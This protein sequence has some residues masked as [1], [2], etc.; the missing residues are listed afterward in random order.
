MFHVER[1]SLIYQGFRRGGA[2]SS[3]TTMFF[4]VACASISAIAIIVKSFL[5]VWCKLF[6]IVPVFVLD[7]VPT[8]VVYTQSLAMSRI[9]CGKARD[10][11]FKSARRLYSSAA[12]I[13]KYFLHNWCK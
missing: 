7:P 2:S 11:F 9:I 12:T 13:V 1:N 5:R 10:K 8:L 3:A 4:G 6:T